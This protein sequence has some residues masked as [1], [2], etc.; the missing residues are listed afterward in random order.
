MNVNRTKTLETDYI[1]RVWCEHA[2]M[3]SLFRDT[4]G[5]TFLVTRHTG[6]CTLEHACGIVAKVMNYTCW[7]NDKI[8][9]DVANK[10][11]S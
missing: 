1:Q 6:G 3:S 7:F 9:A 11:V 10:H 5:R 8:K 2:Q 4:D